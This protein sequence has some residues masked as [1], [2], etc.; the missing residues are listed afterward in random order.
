MGAASSA[1]ASYPE[2]ALA[3][4]ITPNG[5]KEIDLSENRPVGITEVILAVRAL[6]QKEAAQPDLAAGADDQ[7]GIGQFVRVE[8]FADLVDGNL[9]DDPVQ[10]KMPGRLVSQHSGDGVRDLLTPAVSNGHIQ[11]EGV[12]VPRR[13]FRFLDPL[14]R[15]WGE[16]VH[17]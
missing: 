4:L 5:S 16:K 9:I 14:H 15:G 1:P 6:P 10:W 12:I 17:L 7:V 13:L 3:L 8:V 2:S 11:E